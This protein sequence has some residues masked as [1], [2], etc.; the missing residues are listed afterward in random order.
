MLRVFIA[1]KTQSGSFWHA[2]I[3]LTEEAGFVLDS[4]LY[5]EIDQQPSASI[6]PDNHPVSRDSK[7]RQGSFWSLKFSP[8]AFK[9]SLLF[10]YLHD[11]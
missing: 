9:N 5:T 3:N 8:K 7:S 2:T 4:V 6:N 10:F 11:D 1:F